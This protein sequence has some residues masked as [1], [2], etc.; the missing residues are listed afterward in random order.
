VQGWRMPVDLAQ[1]KSVNEVVRDRIIRHAILLEQ[2]KTEQVRK[3]ISFFNR[4]LEPDLLEKLTKYAGKTLTENRLRIMRQSMKDVMAAGYLRMR[5]DLEPDLIDLGKS[6]GKWDAAVI[7]KALPV[8]LSLATLSVPT[9]REMVVNRPID[10]RLVREWLEE[11]GQAQAIKVNRQIMIGVAEGEG[12]DEMVRRIRGT[13]KNRYRD[14]LLA[15]SRRE[16]ESVVR[17]SVSGVVNNV[18]QA[19]YQANADVIAAVQWVA[20]LDSHTC[21]VCAAYDGQTYDLMD[22][23]RPPQHYGCRCTTVPVCKSWKEMGFDFAEM[24]VSERAA[25]NGRVADTVTYG[26]WLKGQGRETQELT[27]G[28][29]KTQLFRSGQLSI[30][31]F[32]DDR[33]RILTLKELESLI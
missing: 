33:G 11:L 8:K 9:I 31:D 16:I 2:Y 14:G 12:V 5:K 17:T 21:E 28:R 4:D 22:G 29:R 23:P 10:G 32:I 20:T 15:R 13:A 7:E 27:L 1:L 24:P 26:Q 18:R 3:I 25:M 19:T 30:R 6:Q